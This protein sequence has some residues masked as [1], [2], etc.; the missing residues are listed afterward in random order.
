MYSF[1][2]T[3]QTSSHTDHLSAGLKSEDARKVS[4]VFGSRGTPVARQH[5]SAR[6]CVPFDFGSELDPRYKHAGV[7]VPEHKVAVCLLFDLS[8]LSVLSK[9]L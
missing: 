5:Q 7:A 3:E 9:S 1:H 2:K 4:E 8:T 6:P